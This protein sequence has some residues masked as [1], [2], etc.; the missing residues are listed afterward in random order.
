MTEPRPIRLGVSAC[1]LGEKVRYDARDKRDSVIAE[2]LPRHFELVPACP[3]V[4]IGLGIPRPPIHL[5]GDPV[6]P[7]VLGVADPERDYTDALTTYATEQL[8]RLS[9][10]SG[11]I[12]KSRSPSCGINDVPVH[13]ESGEV[14]ANGGRGAFAAEWL[15]RR[16][17]LPVVD[18]V[19]L[20]DSG[21][22]GNF[23]GRVYA[24]RRWQE[25]CARG[26]TP[27]SLVDFHTRYKLVLMARDK[28][29]MIEL[30]RMVANP[31]RESLATLAP[32]YFE[33][34][35]RALAVPASRGRHTDTLMHALGYL[36]RR[37]DR[38]EKAEFLASIE[39]FR[40]G[41]AP[42]VAPITLLRQLL[43]CH[44][45]DYLAR[46]Y[47]L[48]WPLTELAISESAGSAGSVSNRSTSP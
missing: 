1:L 7:R 12:F 5:V 16:P 47:Y 2:V 20:A 11:Y 6:Q 27:A 36:K 40:L 28:S 10:L 31:G 30:G 25:L 42:L 3:E 14:M 19:G 48:D 39:A 37:L 43:R 38:D 32:R 18:E 21:V 35:M 22:R 4:A 13:S 34:F 45:D 24:H 17:T 41:R 26:L 9:D 44:L 15:R 29:Q 46:Q 23:L 8:R 33:R